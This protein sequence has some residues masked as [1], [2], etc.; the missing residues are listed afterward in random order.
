LKEKGIFIN[1]SR[2]LLEKR[3]SRRGPFSLA[4]IYKQIKLLET[5]TKEGFDKLIVKKDYE[6]PRDT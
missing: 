4:V 3:Q 6:Q 2:G 1:I 5:P